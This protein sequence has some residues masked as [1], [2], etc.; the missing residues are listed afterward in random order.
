MNVIEPKFDGEHVA[1][2]F[3][4]PRDGVVVDVVDQRRRDLCG[5]LGDLLCEI[6]QAPVRARVLLER[7]LR[8]LQVTTEMVENLGAKRAVLDDEKRQR[9]RFFDAGILLEPRALETLVVV[10]CPFLGVRNG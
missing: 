2:Q 1:V 6:G 4:V 8:L 9:M 3:H 10:D 5:L 7:R